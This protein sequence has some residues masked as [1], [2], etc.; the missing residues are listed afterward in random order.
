[1][2]AGNLIKKCPKCGHNNKDTAMVCS[3]CKTSLT[4]ITPEY[5][6]IPQQEEP[7]KEP[8]PSSPEEHHSKTSPGKGGTILLKAI[9][10]KLS[11]E[12]YPGFEVEIQDGYV[13][14]REG[15][16]D[17]T[18]LPRSKFI[19]RKHAS[20]I[21]QGEIW[22]LRDEFPADP[23]EGK[24]ATKVNLKTLKPGDTEPLKDNDKIVLADT[25]FIFRCLQ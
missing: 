15:D 20:F 8:P 24:N 22:Y 10:P 4:R 7:V 16:I 25:V 21:K 18:V 9:A 3:K 1:M 23:I 5:Y 12:S 14:G 17:V 19:S 11:C 13:I 2:D 6:K